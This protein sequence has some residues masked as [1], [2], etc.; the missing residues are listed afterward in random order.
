MKSFDLSLAPWGPYNKKYLGVSNIA[1]KERGIS[2][3]INLFPGFYRRS[4]LPPK[5]ICDNGAKIL[6]ASADLSHFLIRYELMWKDLVYIDA[7]FT[8]DKSGDMTISLEAVNNTEENQSLTLSAVASLKFPTLFRKNISVMEYK[9]DGKWLDATAYSHISCSEKINN[10]GYLNGVRRLDGFTGA[11]GIYLGLFNKESFIEYSLIKKTNSLSLRYISEEDTEIFIEVKGKKYPLILEK[12]P[13]PRLVE[14]K[15]DVEFDKF[16]L[17]SWGCEAYLDGFISGGEKHIFHDYAK[18][19]TPEITKGD[20]SVTLKYKYAAYEMSWD[21]E[22]YYIRELIGSDIGN[23]LTDSIHNHVS[24]TLYGEGEGHGLDLFICPVFLNAGE[25]KSFSV[26]I[27]RLDKSVTFP[28]NNEFKEILVNSDGE[29]YKLSMDIMSAVTLTNVAYPTYIKGEYIRHST[30]G[31]LWD[32][33]YT[34]DSGF[35]GM[36]L[37]A[38]DKLRGEEN[39]ANYMTDES[40]PAPFIMRGSVVPTQLFLFREIWNSRTDKEFLKEFYPKMLRYYRFFTGIADE[41]TGLIKTWD[42]FYN[43]G[44]WDDYPPQKAVHEN[45]LTGKVYPVITASLTVVFAKVL[46][47]FA[48]LLGLCYDEFD[49]D[50][51]K[52]S[53]SLEKLWDEESGYYGYYDKEEKTIFKAEDVN[54]NMGFD[55][56][57]P[58]IAGVTDKEKDEKIL[59]NILNGLMT[60]I[61]VSVVDKRAPYFSH[62]GYW[63]GSVW[64]P[65]QWVLF[66]TALDKGEATLCDKIAFTAMELW[67]KEVELTYNCYEH[68]MIANGRGSGFHQFSGLSTPVLLWYKAYFSPGTVNAGFFTLIDNLKWEEDY[69]KASFDILSCEEGSHILICL[70]E[71]EDYRLTIDGNAEAFTRVTNGCIRIKAKKGRVICV[72]KDK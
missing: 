2:F 12:A 35:I 14:F 30:P 27:K 24:S 50:I 49:R 40:D 8:C 71:A 23:I 43:S 44:G 53:E 37:N 55:G 16:R 34:W 66:K 28:V 70:S 5:D 3:D 51:K 1:D 20:K 31:R 59:D 57:Y 61:G 64:M 15:C 25:R 38:L 17:Y 48:G 45:K 7:D 65:H 36:G 67:K 29:R 63:N 26:K 32:C 21:Y 56:I 9:G 68:F 52:L 54:F 46:K 60:D 58:F 22:D 18:D 42:Y 39:L 41:E 69:S 47:S 19:Y 4:V 10:E 13:T 6:K 72:K 11:H 33:L 62:R